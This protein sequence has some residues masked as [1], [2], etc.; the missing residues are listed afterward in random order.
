ML[1]L[2]LVLM[3]VPV[4]SEPQK[5]DL[6]KLEILVDTLKSDCPKVDFTRRSKDG[7]PTL[8]DALDF[9][10]L[11]HTFEIRMD[12]ELLRETP[13]RPAR[14]KA[15]TVAEV[16]AVVVASV[17]CEYLIQPDG[18]VLVRKKPAEIVKGPEMKRDHRILGVKSRDNK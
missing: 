12:S 7:K 3:P 14:F 11:V 4:V 1:T 13:L 16:L 17:H 10:N 9:F 2:C 18:S 15:G 6:K 8:G 5:V